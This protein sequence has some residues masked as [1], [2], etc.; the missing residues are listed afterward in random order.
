[1]ERA[2]HVRLIE[3]LRA[4]LGW[5]GG[6]TPPL[7]VP[8]ER[9][10][11]PV[12]HDRERAR[13]FA[14]APRVIAAARAI[15]PGRVVP[16]DV[17]GAALILTR[18]DDG[19]V[20]AHANACRHRGTRLV[21]AACAAKALVCPYHGWTYDLRGRLLH[22]LHAETFGGACD[23]RDLRR[24]AVEERHG[25]IW[26]CASTAGV[27]T[28]LGALAG[29][30][31]A[32]ALDRAIAW[33][34]SRTVRRCNWK[35]VIEAFLD[36]YHLRVLHRDSIYRFFLDA[37]SVGE[38]VGRHIRA[39]SGRRALRDAPPALDGIADLR[40]LGTPSYVLFPGT[41][42][43]EHPDFTSVLTLTPLTAGSTEVEHAMLVPADRAG[44]TE[45]WDKSWA[46]IED[47]V[48]Q[49][50]DLWAC[51]Q[52]Q[53]SIDAGATDEL[54][55]GSLEQPVHWFHAS[56]DAVLQESQC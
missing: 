47:G 38:P 56:L 15:E 39:V 22:A 19:T 36:G 42:V 25:L 46:L 18:D 28:Y 14:P 10:R 9:Y 31:A 29:D 54:L 24:V 6:G 51:E 23:G 50:E 13:A 11:D 20:I 2:N 49:R 27:D 48:V 7:A 26:L 16:V 1:M 55:F 35:L 37:V 45:H 52:I 44:E 43:I 41:V 12:R 40:T 34:T 5:A 21:D 33:R 17:A 4:G 32:L 3:Q 30:L 8:A 53:R